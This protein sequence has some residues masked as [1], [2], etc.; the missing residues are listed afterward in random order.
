VRQRPR[1]H[2]RMDC[3]VRVDHVGDDGRGFVLMCL[4]Q[5]LYCTPE[6]LMSAPA[7]SWH[8]RRFRVPSNTRPSVPYALKLLSAVTMHAPSFGPFIMANAVLQSFPSSCQLPS[9]TWPCPRRVTRHPQAACIRRTPHPIPLV[10]LLNNLHIILLLLS[11]AVS[12]VKHHLHVLTPIPLPREQLKVEGVRQRV[13]EHTFHF[14][15]SSCLVLYCLT[16]SSSAFL[17][18]SELVL[19]IGTISFTVRSVSTPLIMRKHFRS[20]GSGSNVSRT[21]LVRVSMQLSLCGR[22]AVSLKMLGRE[23]GTKRM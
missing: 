1:L 5:S 22:G 20:P 2:A 14:S 8:D 6:P 19:R 9:R 7:L 15:I 16:S 18:P 11:D 4:C 17:R 12:M 3:K 10:R 13:G 21:S 23:G